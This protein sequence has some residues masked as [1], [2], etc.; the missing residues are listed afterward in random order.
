MVFQEGAL[1]DSLTV[2]ENVGYKLFEE[3]QWP[4]EKADARVAG[5]ARLRRPRR[6]HRPHAVGAVRRAAAPRRHRARDGRQA[7][8]PALRRADD[9]AGSDYVADGGRGDHQAARPRRRQLGAGDAPVARRLLRRRARRVAQRR[10][11][12][13]FEP[14][15][16]GKADQAE[17]IMLK[18]GGILFEGNATELREAAKKDEYIRAFSVV[19]D[20]RTNATDTIAGLVGTENRRHGGGRPG[21]HGH[22]G[23]SPSAAPAASPGS[24]TR[25]RPTSPTCRG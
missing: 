25:S 5:S 15:A 8:H 16:E 23:R 2:R 1:F 6:V 20:T 10:R 19:K 14:A 17:F 21:A 11:R 9:G 12:S 18:D 4:A 24:A 3:L 22:A 7:A 13:A